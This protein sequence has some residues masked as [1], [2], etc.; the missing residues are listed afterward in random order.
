MVIIRAMDFPEN[1][2]CPILK[3]AKSIRIAMGETDGKS[4]YRARAVMKTPEAAEQIKT[5]T[6]GFKAMAAASAVTRT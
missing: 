1:V 4:F 3:Q 2:P 5:I 6:E